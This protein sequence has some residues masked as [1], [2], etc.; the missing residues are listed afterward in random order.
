[1]NNLIDVLGRIAA[2]QETCAPVLLSIGGT[3]NGVVRHD[4]IVIHRAPPS[5]VA[6]LVN[7]FEFVSLTHEGLEIRGS[8]RT[9]PVTDIMPDPDATAV[10]HQPHEPNGTFNRRTARYGRG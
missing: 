2:A 9:P 1:M 10:I 6:E 4:R 8:W 5:V 7:S 3:E